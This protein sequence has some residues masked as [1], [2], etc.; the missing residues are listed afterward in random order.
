VDRQPQGS[1]RQNRTAELKGWWE[2]EGDPYALSQWRP[3]EAD[4][5]NY[6]PPEAIHHISNSRE[7]I[8]CFFVR[9]PQ[10][11]G[12]VWQGDLPDDKRAIMQ[13]R[14]DEHDRKVEEFCAD[15]RA[16]GRLIDIETCEGHWDWADERDPYGIE[17]APYGCVNRVSFVRNKDS[18]DWICVDDLPAEKRQA[19]DE[20]FKRERSARE[21]VVDDLF[22]ALR[23]GGLGL[24][25]AV[26]VIA[27]AEKTYGEQIVKDALGDRGPLPRGRR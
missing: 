17:L 9:G 2:S 3:K 15:R 19:L 10:S 25:E 24:A 23:Q 7:Q 5:N 11:R 22:N 27:E 14:I 12:W 1:W 21:H 26:K 8:P 16:A 18:D 20:R 6:E 13:A 4:W